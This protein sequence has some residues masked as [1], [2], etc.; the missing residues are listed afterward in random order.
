MFTNKPY[1]IILFLFPIAVLSFDGCKKNIPQ[2]TPLMTVT[3]VNNPTDGT[4]LVAP[5]NINGTGSGNLY[6]LDKNGSVLNSKTFPSNI[7]DFKKWLING[8]TMYSYNEYNPNGYHIPGVTYS[9]G[10]EVITDANL[11]EIGRFDFLPANGRSSSQNLLD[12]HDFILLS[13]RHYIGIGYYQ[14]KVDNI[15]AS[16]NPSPGLQIV[17]PIVQEVN[18]DKVTWEW[19]AT[20]YPE[21][22][23]SSTSGNFS[24]STQIDDY[25]HMNSLFLDPNDSNLI[26]SF[27]YLNEIIK[28]SR[29]DGSIIWRLGGAN[30]DFPLTSDQKTI[31]QHNATLADSGQTLLVFDNGEA[32]VR[33]FTRIVE[34]QLDEVN[35]HVLS[36]KS[37]PIP[38]NVFT[39]AMGSVQKRG[40]TYFIDGGTGNYVL[41]ADYTTGKILFQMT[42]TE[43]SYRAFKY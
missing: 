19:D 28:V 27:R 36:F 25:A 5:F 17:A 3:S 18:N 23:L 38:N 34:Y 9:A 8:V 21:L 11:N 35:K 37:F 10:D 42:M 7:L 22:Y 1:F 40:N 26:I 16:L 6:M 29:K 15:P 31:W 12:S 20:N 30:S 41:E 14:K 33:A 32:G 13:Q 2:S 24:D 39:S 43:P 4:I